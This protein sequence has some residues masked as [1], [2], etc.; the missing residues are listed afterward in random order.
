MKAKGLT[1]WDFVLHLVTCPT[2]MKQLLLSFVFLTQDLFISIK[3]RT[4]G[5]FYYLVLLH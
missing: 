4:G 2:M 1:A 5:Y 3:G